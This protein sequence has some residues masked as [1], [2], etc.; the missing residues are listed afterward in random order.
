MILGGVVA[1]IYIWQAVV[2]IPSSQ[3]YVERSK[4]TCYR[5]VTCDKE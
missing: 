1:N 5:M 3:W 4:T 2:I